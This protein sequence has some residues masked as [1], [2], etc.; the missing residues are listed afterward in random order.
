MMATTID[1]EEMK[2]LELK[3][4]VSDLDGKEKR[5]LWD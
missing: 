3:D 5:N 1:C 2:V 4:V